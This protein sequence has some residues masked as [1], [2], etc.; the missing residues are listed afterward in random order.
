MTKMHPSSGLRLVVVYHELPHPVNHGGRLDVWRRLQALAA[1]GVQIHLVCWRNP[2]LGE[3]DPQGDSPLRSVLTGLT[4]LQEKGKFA[5]SHLALSMPGYARRRLLTQEDWL[6]VQR[7]LT[8]FAPQ[9]LLLEGPFA[10]PAAQR[11]AQSQGIKL[12][13]RSHNIESRYARFILERAKGW[14]TRFNAWLNVPGIDR[15]ESAIFENASW[16]FDI[17]PEDARHWQAQGHLNGEWLP[18]VVEQAWSERVSQ[19]QAWAPAYHVG[20]LGNL[21]QPNNVEGVLW[22][23]EQVVPVLRQRL[24]GLKGFIAGS[25]PV[26]AVR[27]A[28]ARAGF[29]L[30]ANPADT[31]PVLRNACTLVNPVF[32]GS[33]VNTK[34]IEM[35][36]TPAGL[37]AT[38]VAL[39]GLADEARRCFGVA[40]TPDAFADLIIQR[41]TGASAQKDARDAARACYDSRRI[42]RLI[43]VLKGCTQVEQQPMQEARHASA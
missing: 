42:E 5:N 43:C 28:T 40:D 36:F 4:V 16:Y 9:A 29:D 1:Q 30:L 33:G 31:E 21:Y 12:I 2:A 27:Q 13:Y 19:P 24:P 26:E 17:S 37:V 22:F 18:P 6:Q 25:R 20:Y 23:L 3:A 10:F 11:I 38:P 41:Q 34:C 35:L 7:D 39:Q 32:A 8:T 14:R 15:L